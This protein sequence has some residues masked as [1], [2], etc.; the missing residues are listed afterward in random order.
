MEW[1]AVSGWRSIP[2]TGEVLEKKTKENRGHE[3]G[4]EKNRANL[5]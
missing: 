1:L 3:T 2:R 4:K 5:H